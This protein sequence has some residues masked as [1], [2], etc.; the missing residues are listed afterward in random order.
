MAVTRLKDGRWVVYYRINSGKIKKEYF[1]RGGRAKEKAFLRNDD[2]GYAPPLKKP[3]TWVAHDSD[4]TH[5]VEDLLIREY[6]HKVRFEV[7]V[8]AGSIDALTPSE[9]I[10]IK[11]VKHWKHAL[12]Q[13]LCYGYCL[14]NRDLRIYL[15]GEVLKEHYEFICNV[16]RSFNVRVSFYGEMLESLPPTFSTLESSQSPAGAFRM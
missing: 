7:R 11:V 2:L 5:K 12:G 6:G 9:I 13:V 8:A 1:G 4:Y 15:Y 16:C 10:E 3:E 14:P